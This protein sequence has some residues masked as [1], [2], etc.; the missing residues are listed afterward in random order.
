MAVGTRKK[1]K[2]RNQKS[3][4]RK[5]LKHRLAVQYVKGQRSGIRRATRAAM[6]DDD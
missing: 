1:A 3:D 5:A 4:M 2:P 6:G